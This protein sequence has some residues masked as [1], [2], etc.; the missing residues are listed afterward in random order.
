MVLSKQTKVPAFLEDQRVPWKRTGAGVG[1]D[2]SLWVTGRQMAWWA[3]CENRMLTKG[4]S[5]A[6]C[7]Q[8]VPPISEFLIEKKIFK[9]QIAFHVIRVEIVL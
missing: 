6:F 4:H 3:H 7:F 8:A 2:W 5:L 9:S 1:R